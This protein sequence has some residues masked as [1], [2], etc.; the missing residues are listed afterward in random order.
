MSERLYLD[1]RNPRIGPPATY[2][3]V[4]RRRRSST[5]AMVERMLTQHEIEA[6]RAAVRRDRAL[7]AAALWLAIF[8]IL[9]IAAG[10]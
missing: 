4:R 9:V 3:D 10:R 6:R 7:T 5:P 1:G 2:Q 8:V